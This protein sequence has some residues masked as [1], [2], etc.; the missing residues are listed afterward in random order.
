MPAW[1]RIVS[2]T[3]LIP[4][5]SALGHGSMGYP[6]SRTYNGFQE[7]PE[8]PISDAVRDAVECGGAQPLYDWHEVVNFFP[9]TADYQRDVPYNQHIPDGRLASADNDKYACFDAARDDWP[10]TEMTSGPT[11]LVWAAAVV[12]N[13]SVFRVWL[14]TDDWNPSSDLNWGQMVELDVEDVALVGNEYFINVDLPERTGRHV[15]YCIWQRLDPVGEGFYSA[16]D[17]IFVE[18]DG[19]DDDDDNDDSEP[20]GPDSASI[21]LVN[22]WDG[23]WQGEV[24]IENSFGDLSMLNWTI[25]WDGGPDIINLWD[26]TSTT[27]GNHTIVQGEAWNSFIPSGGSSSFGFIAQGTWPPTFSNVILNGFE[28][29]LDGAPNDGDTTGCSGDV[30]LDDVVDV[31][32]M[33]LVLDGWDSTDP[34]NPADLDDDGVVAVGDVLV[35]LEAW[36]SCP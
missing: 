12:H 5:A 8:N 17:V 27:D 26:A 2:L 11:Q 21:S 23:S 18:D 1:T 32:D 24:I 25:E 9:G 19:N 14:T 7:G 4:A 30:N 20:Q 10:A 35:I 6:V 16:S 34:G 22:S 33:L 36:G 28:I 31:T 3:V 13:P 15:L 29:N